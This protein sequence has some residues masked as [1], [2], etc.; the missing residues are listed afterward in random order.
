VKRPANYGVRIKEL[1]KELETRTLA[2]AEAARGITKLD[3]TGVGYGYNLQTHRPKNLK[4]AYRD[5]A[6]DIIL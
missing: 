4:Q 3:Y 1:Q 5:V 6:S 2:E